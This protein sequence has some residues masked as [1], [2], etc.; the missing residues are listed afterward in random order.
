MTIATS[1]VFERPAD[2]AAELAGRPGIV[3][4]LDVAPVRAVL[5]DGEG[6]PVEPAT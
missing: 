4:F 6:Q 3:R 2:R 5:V 1:V